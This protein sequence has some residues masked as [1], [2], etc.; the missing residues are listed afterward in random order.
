MWKK[1]KLDLQQLQTEIRTMSPRSKLY[2]LLVA[3]LSSLGHW[4]Q[5]R[6]GKAGF[7]IKGENN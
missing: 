1:S 3:E 7:K 2:K 5:L 4:K 6:R